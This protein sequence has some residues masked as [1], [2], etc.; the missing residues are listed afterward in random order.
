[1][2][3]PREAATPLELPPIMLLAGSTRGPPFS[4]EQ[5]LLVLSP[6]SVPT[7]NVAECMRGLMLRSHVTP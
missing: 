7:G 1:M 2:E 3:V 6:G 4:Q 5:L